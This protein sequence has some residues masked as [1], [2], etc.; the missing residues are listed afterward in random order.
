MCVKCYLLSESIDKKFN[1]DLFESQIHVWIIENILN[2]ETPWQVFTSTFTDS[3]PVSNVLI[4]DGLTRPLF[5]YF[6]LF[7]SK[8]VLCKIGRWLDS[9]R[10]PMVSEAT[11]LPTEPQP[12]PKIVCFLS[13]RPSQDVFQLPLVPRIEQVCGLLLVTLHTNK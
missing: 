2:T 1:L 12:L 7:H 9:N 4:Q 6:C 8:Q 10:G 5:V 11:A 3:N 13:V